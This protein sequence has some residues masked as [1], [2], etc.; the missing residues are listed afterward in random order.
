MLTVSGGTVAVTIS[1]GNATL[2]NLGAVNQTG[3]GRAI[4]DNTG[5]A[6]LKIYNGSDGQPAPTINSR[7]PSPV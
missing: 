6:G 7:P 5:V 1:G 2:T 3:T 4:R